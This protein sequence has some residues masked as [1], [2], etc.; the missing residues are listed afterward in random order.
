MAADIRFLKT[1]VLFGSWPTSTPALDSGLEFILYVIWARWRQW[2]SH[3]ER[4]S[5]SQIWERTPKIST[6]LGQNDLI[7]GVT[8]SV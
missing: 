8:P 5:L 2:H 3:A 4:N 1:T 7:L 6:N